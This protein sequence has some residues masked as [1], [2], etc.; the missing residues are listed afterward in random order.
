MELIH[1]TAAYSNAVLVAVLPHVSDFAKKLDLPLPQPITAQMVKE[2]RPNPY[3]DY[4][5]GGIFFSNCLFAF[6]NGT[7]DN[8][9]SADN[10]FY[11]DDPAANIN[12]YIG[13]DNMTT[14]QAIA[15]GRDA[16]Q[17]LGYDPKVLACDVSPRSFYGPQDLKDGKHIPYC[18]IQWERY[19]EAE[20]TSRAM[21]TNN[22]I[23][24]IEI[25]MEKKTIVGLHFTSRKIWRDPPQVDVEPVMESDVKK[26]KFGPMFK[27]TNAPPMPR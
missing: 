2:F 14:N 18:K 13:K 7:V 1:M 6:E 10:V 20:V 22:D 19:A 8:F 26:H 16:L 24:T 23:V 27:K 21:Q 4:I 17:K 5:G 12:K 3:K 11:D 25:N 9:R 15:L